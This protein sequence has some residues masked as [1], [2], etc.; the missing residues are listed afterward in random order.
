MRSKAKRIKRMKCFVAY[1]LLTSMSCMLGCE[2]VPIGT[3]KME[4][5]TQ[6]LQVNHYVEGRLSKEFYEVFPAEIPEETV[7]QRYVYRYECAIAGMPSYYLY[8]NLRMN[9]ADFD[10]E[11]DRLAQTDAVAQSWIGDKCYVIFGGEKDDFQRYLDGRIEDGRC[12]Y[13][14]IAVIDSTSDAVEYFDAQVYDE[15]ATD[16]EIKDLLNRVLLAME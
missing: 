16:A 3:E 10:R 13:F 5:P 6:Y 15:F 11:V 4:D 7:Y 8:L 12:F 1:L 9:T 14:R 2:R